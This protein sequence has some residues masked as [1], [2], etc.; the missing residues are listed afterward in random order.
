MDYP[1][2]L[3]ENQQEQGFNWNRNS[4]GIGIT[5]SWTTSDGQSATGQNVD[6]TFPSS[7][8]YQVTL[9]ITDKYGNTSVKTKTVTATGSHLN[10]VTFDPVTG[11]GWEGCYLISN[12]EKTGFWTWKRIDTITTSNY[13]NGAEHGPYTYVFVSLTDP[14]IYRIVSGS[15]NYGLRHGVWDDDLGHGSH[16]IA[17]YEN[18]DLNGPYEQLDTNNW[19]QKGNYVYNKMDG[20]WTFTDMSNGTTCVGVYDNNVQISYTCP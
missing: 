18:N 14:T 5:Y 1:T 4:T 12:G 9:T 7:G 10:C 15:Y 16:T 11:L 3:K 20:V 17:T 6:F 19:L 2:K 8:D 13:D